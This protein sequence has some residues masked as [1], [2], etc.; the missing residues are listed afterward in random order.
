MSSDESDTVVCMRQT[1]PRQKKG[2]TRSNGLHVNATIKNY[3]HVQSRSKEVEIH[4]VT[5]QLHLCKTKLL[6]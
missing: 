2:Q 5:V 3:M 4:L 6:S 1:I